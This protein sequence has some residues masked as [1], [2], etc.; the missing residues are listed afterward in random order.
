V[1]AVRA[2]GERDDADILRELGR[3]A[4]VGRRL[5]GHDLA[6]LLDDALS[7][8]KAGD[9]V[10]VV[11]RRPHRDDEPLGLGAALAQTDLERLLGDEGIL[12]PARALLITAEDERRHRGVAVRVR[13][14]ASLHSAP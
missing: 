12:L 8:E 4:G 9:E 6:D 10:V 13:H 11:A 3:D 1:P 5:D 2:R 14:P 7:V